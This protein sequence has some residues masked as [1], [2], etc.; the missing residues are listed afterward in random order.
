MKPRPLSETNPYLK[1][2]AMRQKL[3]SRSVKT[4]GGVEGIKVAKSLKA[5][6]IKIP[7]RNK[8]IYPAI[9][10]EYCKYLLR[11]AMVFI[12]DIK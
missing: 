4:S 7:R 10:H 8:K 1:T 2:P 5:A 9:V 6:N 12:I 11:K 3:V